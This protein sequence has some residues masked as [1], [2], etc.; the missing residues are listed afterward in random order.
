MYDWLKNQD[1]A[2]L[3]QILEHFSGSEEQSVIDLPMKSD[4]DSTF[5][6]KCLPPRVLIFRHHVT[7]PPKLIRYKWSDLY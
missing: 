4:S 7:T 2:S 5:E 1:G 3:S 6:L